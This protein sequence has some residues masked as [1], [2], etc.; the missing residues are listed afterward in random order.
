MV[1]V[2]AK[3]K[4]SF[5]LLL[6]QNIAIVN[7]WHNISESDFNHLITFMKNRVLE[8]IRK[9]WRINIV[10]ISILFSI[11]EKWSY[12]LLTVYFLNYFALFKIIAT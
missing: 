2:I 8:S 5:N 9:K 10:L 11:L 12:N 6:N 7:E 1:F 3:S 4:L